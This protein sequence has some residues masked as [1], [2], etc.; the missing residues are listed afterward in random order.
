M[1]TVAL[2]MIMGTMMLLIVPMVTVRFA[3][4]QSSG[5]VRSMRL[6]PP[7]RDEKGETPAFNQ[8]VRHMQSWASA[9]ASVASILRRGVEWM[10]GEGVNEED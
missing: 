10:E 3:M 4:A 5:R 2:M 1:Q 8:L 6:I 7:V 9:E